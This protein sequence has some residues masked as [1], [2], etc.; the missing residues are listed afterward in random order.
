MYIHDKNTIPIY[1]VPGPYLW[2]FS[3][4][5]CVARICVCIVT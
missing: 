1:G 5:T 2:K 4:Y 3:N